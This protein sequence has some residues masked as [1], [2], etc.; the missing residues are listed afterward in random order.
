[1]TKSIEDILVCIHN[2]PGQD[3]HTQGGANGS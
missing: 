1:M 3:E 2:E